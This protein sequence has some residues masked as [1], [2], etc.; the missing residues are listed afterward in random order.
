MHVLLESLPHASQRI[1]GPLTALSSTAQSS[2]AFTARRG[3][4]KCGI[5]AIPSVTHSNT[6]RFF[7]V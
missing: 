5:F 4:E 7:E 6:S 2:S 1:N 3:A